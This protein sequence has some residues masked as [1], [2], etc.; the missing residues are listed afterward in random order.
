[1]PQRSRARSRISWFT[2][3]NGFLFTSSLI[4]NRSNFPH[5]V[6]SSGADG[7]LLRDLLGPTLEQALS[8]GVLL[9]QLDHGCGCFLSR[10]TPLT[11]CGKTWRGK[12]SSPIKSSKTNTP[13]RKAFRW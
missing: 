2:Q 9:R 5:L 3:V 1:M 4:L 11:F 12:V 10:R 6:R 13:L 8:S 7:H